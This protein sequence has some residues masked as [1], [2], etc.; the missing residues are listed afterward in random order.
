LASSA[1]FVNRSPSPTYARNAAAKH[2]RPV[3]RR[4][5]LRMSR[6]R[7]SFL[8]I[9][10]S[11]MT[12]SGIA[13]AGEGDMKTCLAMYITSALGCGGSFAELCSVDFKS[14]VVIVG[15]DGPHDIRISDKKPTIRGLNLM[16]GKKGYGVSVEFSIKQGPVT[17]VSLGSDENGQFRFIVAEGESQAGWVPPIGNTLTR[18]CFGSDAASF[19]EDWRKTGAFHHQS[20]AIGHCGNMV[21]KFGKLMGIKTIRLR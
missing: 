20:L 15:H 4:G 10:N 18:G 11:L 17:M 9:G 3:R 1:G 14:D 8:T 13:M 19:L 6:F 7:D 16:H 21:E 5:I 2:P 12:T